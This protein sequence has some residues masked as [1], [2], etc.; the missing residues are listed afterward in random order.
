MKKQ[1]SEHTGPSAGS[2]LCERDNSPAF[3]QIL[4]KIATIHLYDIISETGYYTSY[5]IQFI[6][7]Q[8]SSRQIK[9]SFIFQVYT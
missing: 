7:K 8:I 3:D 4:S 5:F 1:G 6:P 2:I 9:G